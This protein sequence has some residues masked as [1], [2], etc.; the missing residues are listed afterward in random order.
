[1]LSAPLQVAFLKFAN[2]KL[3]V[4]ALLTIEM[5]Y[6]PHLVMGLEAPPPL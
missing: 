3:Q 4:S 1:M 5:S 6:R 2:L